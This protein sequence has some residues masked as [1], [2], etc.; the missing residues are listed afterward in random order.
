[1]EVMRVILGED[2]KMQR[3][4]IVERISRQVTPENR[5]GLPFT[6]NF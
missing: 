2:Q 1:M 3:E 6:S 5:L 4:G